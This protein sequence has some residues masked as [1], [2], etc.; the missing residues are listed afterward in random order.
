MLL[1]LIQILS[2]N[3]SPNGK[4]FVTGS[5]DK[6]TRIYDIHKNYLLMLILKGSRDYVK[7]INY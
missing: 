7:N 6:F 4:Q 2:L 3:F 5:A 1:I